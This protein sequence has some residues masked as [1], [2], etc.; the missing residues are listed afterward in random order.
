LFQN[1]SQTTQNLKLEPSLCVCVCEKHL[2]SSVLL[3]ILFI[4]Q[5]EWLPGGEPE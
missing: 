1:P 4:F 3:V 2:I 5:T